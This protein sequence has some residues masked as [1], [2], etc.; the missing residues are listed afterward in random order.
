[1]T[2]KYVEDLAADFW[3]CVGSEEPFPRGLEHSI[4]CAKPWG[5]VTSTSL[6]R[7][8]SLAGWSH[9]TWWQT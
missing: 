8:C 9:A 5:E 6:G 4:R 1:M 7:P 3:E 2:S